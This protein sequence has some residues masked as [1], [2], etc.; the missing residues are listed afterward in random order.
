MASL[1]APVS[2]L[3]SELPRTEVRNASDFK[4]AQEY[5]ANQNDSRGLSYPIPTLGIETQYRAADLTRK[6]AT[7]KPIQSL[8]G[9]FLQTAF[10]ALNCATTL[11]MQP[12][13]NPGTLQPR[14]NP[15]KPHGLKPKPANQSFPQFHRLS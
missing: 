15:Q 6:N 1:Q 11:R 2:R 7:A 10:S 4:Q 8:C 9:R 5:Q 3:L 13:P 12:K 14:L